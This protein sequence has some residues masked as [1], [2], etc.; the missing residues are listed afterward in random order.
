MCLRFEVSEKCLYALE[1][2]F[3]FT[4]NLVSF[5][6]KYNITPVIESDLSSSEKLDSVYSFLENER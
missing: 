5:Y 4:N 1:N 3:D 6:K 2:F